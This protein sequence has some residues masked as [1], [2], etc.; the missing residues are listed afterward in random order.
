MNS[1]VLLMTY[2]RPENTQLIL[3]LLKKYKQKNVIVFNDGLK[4]KEHLS[5]HK[6][7]RE[8]I[9]KFE[10]LKKLEIIFP[11]KNLTQKNNL[12]FALKKVFKK[13]ER[14]IILEDD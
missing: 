14:A 6:K 4:K 12:P 1:P 13:Y 11:K 10:G 5:E 2:R 8:I 9:S 3:Q 7:T